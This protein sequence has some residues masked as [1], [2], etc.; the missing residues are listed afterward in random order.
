LPLEKLANLPGI[1]PL[2]M[3]PSSPQ[4]FPHSPSAAKPSWSTPT[5]RA[6]GDPATTSALVPTSPQQP[7]STLFMPVRRSSASTAPTSTT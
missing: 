2:R 6:I 3:A 7:A 5:G 4:S 1:P